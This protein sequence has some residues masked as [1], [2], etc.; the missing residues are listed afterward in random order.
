MKR[1][2]FL[3]RAGAGALIGGGLLA[4]C[5]QN[6]AAGPAGSTA[7]AAAAKPAAPRPAVA[8]AARPALEAPGASAWG[9]PAPVAW[10]VWRVAG[11]TFT[12]I[13]NR[14]GHHD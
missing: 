5:S 14:R 12:A 8:G 13:G 7:T 1:R 6:D 4:G 9:A 3:G 10:E 11:P 2:D